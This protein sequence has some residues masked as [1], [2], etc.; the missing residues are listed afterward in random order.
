MNSLPWAETVSK[1]AAVAVRRAIVYILSLYE[2]LR[3]IFDAGKS[4]DLRTALYI[5]GQYS[6]RRVPE[7]STVHPHAY[8]LLQPGF[9]AL[10]NSPWYHKTSHCF[11]FTRINIV[12]NTKRKLSRCL[13]ILAPHVYNIVLRTAPE[14]MV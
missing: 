9:W 11:S 4:L 5:A 2:C 8:R 14:M 1:K 6:W 3:Q 10:S 12:T 7:I 13:A